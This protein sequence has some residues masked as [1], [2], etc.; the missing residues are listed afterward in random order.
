MFSPHKMKFNEVNG[1]LQ[2]ILTT[3][4]M[5]DLLPL[6]KAV[7]ATLDCLGIL[8]LVVNLL[9]SFYV[10]SGERDYITSINY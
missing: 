2:G 8:L 7:V 1:L 10:F 4:G 9:L 3:L 6:L 5:F